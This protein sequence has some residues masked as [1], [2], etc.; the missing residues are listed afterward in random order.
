MIILE[1]V[2]LLNLT[3]KTRIYQANTSELYGKAKETPHNEDPFI[4][5]VHKQY[6]NFMPTGSQLIIGKLMGCMNA[7][8]FCL[9]MSP[10]DEVKHLS[11]GKLQEDGLRSIK[12]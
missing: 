8:E 9:I 1:A 4:Q 2:R 5:E 3:P 11:L 6:Q 7:M 10:P 12:G